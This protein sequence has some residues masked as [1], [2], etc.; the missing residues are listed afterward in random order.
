MVAIP[1][2]AGDQEALR[3]GARDLLAD[4]DPPHLEVAAGL[5]QDPDDLAR[6]LDLLFAGI[7]AGIPPR[8]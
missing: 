7:R 8:A 5:M 2:A 6:G 1:P 4:A 3:A